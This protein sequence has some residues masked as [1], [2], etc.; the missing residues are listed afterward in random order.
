MTNNHHLVMQ[1]INGWKE[2]DIKQI[3]SCLSEN[4]III[5]SHGPTYHGIS[6]VTLWFKFWLEAKSYIKKWNI[7]S[8]YECE[9]EN[10]VFVEWDFACVS[11]GT[12]YTFPGI[13]VIK[14]SER[15]ICFIQEYRMTRSAYQWKKDKLE[16]T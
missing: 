3:T 8:F 10:T 12:E 1:Y 5:E 2:N 14:F 16:S 13:S 15:K 6:D 7:L 9:K 4:C 11:N